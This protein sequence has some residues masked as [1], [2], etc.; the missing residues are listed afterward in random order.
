MTDV[1]INYFNLQIVKKLEINFYY[2]SKFNKIIF[3][4]A[5]KQEG[6]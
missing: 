6:K 4:Y 1:R 3:I 5:K 2:V